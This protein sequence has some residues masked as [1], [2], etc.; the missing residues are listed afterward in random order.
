MNATTNAKAVYEAW[1][2]QL[3]VDPQSNA[4]WHHLLRAHLNAERD[5]AGKRV[6]EIGCGRGDFSCWLARQPE[7]PAEIVAADFAATAVRKGREFAGSQGLSG[8]TWEEQDIQA[9]R[10][11]DASF[12]TVI[13]CETIEH[14]PD[15]RQALRELARVLKPGGRLF[16]T[17][18]NYLGVYGLY[19]AYLRLRGRPY[20]EVGQPINNFMLL[21]LTRAWVA[22]TGLRIKKVD[23]IG[24]YFLWPGQSA[25]ELPALN[26]PR[27][28]M[29]W[30]ALHSL[31]VGEK[32]CGN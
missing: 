2:A 4:P 6:L 24:H 10:Q 12:D 3:D 23:G 1:H 20:T 8:I 17:T 26:E 13:S 14:V 18:P 28:V 32:P 22:Q 27:S 16:V 19:R 25:K 21:P 30:V 29:R 15:P 7:R 31:V 9:I 5:L 11:P